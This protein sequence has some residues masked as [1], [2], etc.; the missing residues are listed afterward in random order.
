MVF[1]VGKSNGNKQVNKNAAKQ[2]STDSNKKR[3]WQ[4]LG[5]NLAMAY[6]EAK[7][8]G[9]RIDYSFTESI[10]MRSQNYY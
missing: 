5:V 4:K 6:Q 7:A 8:E 10:N 1:V 9:R 2:K 3:E